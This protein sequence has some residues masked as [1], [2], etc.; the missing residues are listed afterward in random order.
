MRVVQTHFEIDEGDSGRV[1]GGETERPLLVC[2]GMTFVPTSRAAAEAF[3]G[4]AVALA[5]AY[6]DYDDLLKIGDP[7]RICATGETGLVEAIEG[8]VGWVAVKVSDNADRLIPCRL[9]NLERIR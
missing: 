9:E 2:G 1:I 8:S 6:G 3:A 5:A 4:A 7:V